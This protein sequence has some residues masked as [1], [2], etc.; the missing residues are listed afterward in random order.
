[1]TQLQLDSAVEDLLREIASDPESRLLRVA[2]PRDFEILFDRAPA[3]TVATA[4]ITK[5]E[6][7]LLCAHRGELAWVLREA[8]RTRLLRDPALDPWVGR[9]DTVDRRSE[10][11][12]VAAWK[13]LAERGF[14]HD[15]SDPLVSEGIHL[16]EHCVR[17]EFHRLDIAQLAVASFRLEPTDQ[18]RIYV[19]LDLALRSQLAMSKRTLQEVLRGEPSVRNNASAWHNLALTLSL[20]GD[21]VNACA[22]ARNSVRKET[23]R[24]EHLLNWFAYTLK[25]RN[26]HEALEAAEAIRGLL[27]DENEVVQLF[28]DQ[29]RSQ[30]TSAERIRADT[31]DFVHSI[32]DQL[33]VAARRVANV[34]L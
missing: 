11:Y 7:H 5:A 23:T 24:P 32:M 10:S 16:L 18:A 1:M 28:E 21:F 22:A 3:V 2:R 8:C 34:L 29:L 19:G 31:R 20:E 17:P 15:S 14:R 12:D 33:P 25:A 6:R 9:Y 13:R 26:K 30:K 4:G 27:N